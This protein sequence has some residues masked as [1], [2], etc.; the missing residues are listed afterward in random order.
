MLRLSIRDSAPSAKA[1][2]AR[3]ARGAAIARP[4]T[5]LRGDV[6][7][8]AGGAISHPAFDRLARVPL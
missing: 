5:D 7:L 1:E 8:R 3:R 4:L 2:H 6:L